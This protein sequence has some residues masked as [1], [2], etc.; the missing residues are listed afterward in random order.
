MLGLLAFCES[1][2]VI[3][4]SNRLAGCVATVLR[5]RKWPPLFLPPPVISV[6]IIFPPTSRLTRGKS[7]KRRS[8]PGLHLLPS[9]PVIPPL[10]KVAA[11]RFADLLHGRPC[12]PRSHLL[13]PI[14]V[15]TS[16]LLARTK[17][18][19]SPIRGHLRSKLGAWSP[20]RAVDSIVNPSNN[21]LI[22]ISHQFFFFS[23]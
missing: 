14:P 2:L 5:L 18:R 3:N 22:T 10:Q 9:C 16:T 8:K 6:Q 19:N 4:D 1:R 12:E 17:T 11:R 23:F 13:L 20:I 15:V 7:S 21:Y